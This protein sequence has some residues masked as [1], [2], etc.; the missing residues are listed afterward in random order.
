[1]TRKADINTNNP[2]LDLVAAFWRQLKS[3]IDGDGP[4]CGDSDDELEVLRRDA[5]AFVSSS[6]F[7]CWAELCNLNPEPLRERLTCQL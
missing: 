5:L 4:L 7:D 2:T 6:G 3:D 1:M